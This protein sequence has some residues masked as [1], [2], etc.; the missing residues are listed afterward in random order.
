MPKSPE[1]T[2]DWAD[3]TYSFALYGKQLE[4]LQSISFNPTSGKKGVG[5]AAI[6][7]RVVGWNWYVEDLRNIVRLALIGGGMSP[8]RAEQLC[9]MYVDGQPLSGSM[10][11]ATPDSPLAL[12]QAIM[13]AVFAGVE[14]PEDD[15][16]ESEEAP[17]EIE[18]PNP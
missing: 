17:G 5:I 14:T 8:V 2:L 4:E 13:Q 7:M 9:R 18:T 10:G 12:A 3:G 15:E 16:D 1:V 11:Q 6:A